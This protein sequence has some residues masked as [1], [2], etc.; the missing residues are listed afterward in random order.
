VKQH[1]G[2]ATPFGVEYDPTTGTSVIYD[3]LW[4]GLVRI[5][6]RFPRCQWETATACDLSEPQLFGIAN[7]T[8]FY[9]ADSN[10]YRCDAAVRGRLAELF[11]K[12]PALYRECE[13]RHAAAAPPPSRGEVA[14]L[15]EATFGEPLTYNEMGEAAE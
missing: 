9:R 5:R 4:R 1:F 15:I 7:P 8:L 11:R 14:D 2:N 13:R 6:G 12:C 3:R 10:S